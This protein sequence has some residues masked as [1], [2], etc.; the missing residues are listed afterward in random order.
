MCNYIYGNS[1]S[2]GFKGKGLVKI[3]VFKACWGVCSSMKYLR[4]KSDS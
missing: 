2:G 1:N 4:E 3:L